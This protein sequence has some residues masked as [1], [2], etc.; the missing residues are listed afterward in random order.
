M[1]TTAYKGKLSFSEMF[2]EL[3]YPIYCKLRERY[4]K[5]IERTD[6]KKTEQIYEDDLTD[7]FN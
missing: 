5:S 3:P 2:Y 4:L 6:D 1:M 7:E